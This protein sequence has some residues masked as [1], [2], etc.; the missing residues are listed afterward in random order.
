LHARFSIRIPLGIGLGNLDGKV[1]EGGSLPN[2]WFDKGPDYGSYAQAW[3]GL[4]NNGPRL[5]ALSISQ[6]VACNLRCSNHPPTFARPQDLKYQI[7]FFP[8]FTLNKSEN[9]QITLTAGAN[10][11]YMDKYSISEYNSFTS[12]KNTAGD[13]NIGWIQTN[14]KLVLER[15]TFFFIRGEYLLGFD[16]KVS[17]RMRIHVETGFAHFVKG[18]G[19]KPD[20]IYT[21]LDN[22]GYNLIKSD[23]NNTDSHSYND[24]AYSTKTIPFYFINR[25]SL[26]YRIQ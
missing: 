25:F 22:K 2:H 7:G 13:T 16:F 4:Y 21:N 26:K 10:F 15:N 9:I 14:S 5:D 3:P 19:D 1:I 12:I 17:E 6:Q 18:H 24:E 11:G 23:Y 20:K 8:K